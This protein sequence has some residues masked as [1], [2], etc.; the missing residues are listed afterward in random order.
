VLLNEINKLSMLRALESGQYLSVA[1]HSRDLYDFLLLHRRTK[2]SWAIKTA[3]QLEKPRYVIFALQTGR[4]NVMSENTS[5]FDH[6]RLN[7]VKL[8]LNLEC[9]LYNDMNLDFDKNRWSIFYD[10]YARF[11][12]NYYGYDYLEPNQTVTTFRH[13]DP[14][15]IID[16]SR[17]NESIK[18]ATVDVRIEFEWRTYP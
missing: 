13:N 7:N 1:F 17:Q 9:Y 12:K 14:F 6:C 11:C 5:L 10:T 15:M 16:C 8:Y 3:T 4:K 2:H 18:S